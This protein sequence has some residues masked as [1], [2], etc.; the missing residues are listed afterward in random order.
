MP[1]AFEPST[2]RIIL[3][4]TAVTATEPYSRSV[5][6]LAL[7]DNAKY[8]SVFR[9]VGSDDLGGGGPAAGAPAGGN[10]NAFHLE[11]Q[12]QAAIGWLLNHISNGAF[13]L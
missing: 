5:D 9:Q 7:S 11:Q 12:N 8:G 4:S 13:D 2:R 3:D 1:I 10:S 6:W